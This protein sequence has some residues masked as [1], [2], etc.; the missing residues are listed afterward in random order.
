[1]SDIKF[2]IAADVASA[3]AGLKKV[4]T[5]LS[6]TA[7]EAQKVDSRLQGFGTSV[8]N[9][10]AKTSTMATAASSLKSN[11]LSIINPTTLLI[12]GLIAMGKALYDFVNRETEAEKNTAKF[13][14]VVSKAGNAFTKA[15]MEVQSLRDEI[16]SFGKGI[17]S[18]D[19]IVKHFNETLGKTVGKVTSVEQAERSLNA[20]AEAYVYATTAKAVANA[21]Y[22][23]SYDII[24]KY[25]K[26]NIE[27]ERIIAD[28]K[29]QGSATSAQ[30]NRVTQ[31][32]KENEALKKQ[33]DILAE[34][35]NRALD[36]YNKIAEKLERNKKATIQVGEI[37]KGEVKVKEVTFKT[38][39]IK[40]IADGKAEVGGAVG[41]ELLQRSFSGAVQGAR[42]GEQ[43]GGDVFGTLSGRRTPEGRSSFEVE[44]EK[45][46]QALLELSNIATSVLSPALDSVF[47]NIGKGANKVVQSLGNVIKQLTIAVFK[48]LALQTIASLLPGGKALNI[49]DVIRGVLGG[50]ASGTTAFGGG[51]TMVGERGPELVNLPSG[52]SVMPNNQL[53]AFGNSGIN[54]MP[55]IAYD[56]TMFRIFLNR[57]DAQISRNG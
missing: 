52:S 31:I 39:K 35:K 26:N 4:Q 20:N 15:S 30:F 12:G 1:M 19:D 14:E 22:A 24:F 34:T 32:N 27:A 50:K 21:A 48:A 42:P 7:I 33:I 46:K 49:G 37:E 43:Q 40:I 6:K 36:T 3:D 45:R 57:V 55:S 41:V 47:D 8:Q 44:A 28:I 9:A 25:L 5:E 17:G 51:L 23:E 53:Q 10:A 2:V 13:V 29:K 16:E 11:L 54:L 56:G 38:P 18:K